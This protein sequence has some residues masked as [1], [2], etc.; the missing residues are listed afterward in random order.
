MWYRKIVRV[1]LKHR[2]KV[3]VG[4][5][6][7]AVTDISAR[8]KNVR[9]AIQ[10]AALAVAVFRQLATAGNRVTR[11]VVSVRILTKNVLMKVMALLRRK[12][13]PAHL[14]INALT[15]AVITKFVPVRVMMKSVTAISAAIMPLVI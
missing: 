2:P 7:L 14:K 4:T 15:T 3:K 9:R 10:P 13:T 11:I 1:L 5:A 6:F 8:K 12:I